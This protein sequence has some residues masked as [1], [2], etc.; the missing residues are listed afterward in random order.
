[1][2]LA[3]QLHAGQKKQG[4]SAHSVFQAIPAVWSTEG[5][6]AREIVGPGVSGPAGRVGPGCAFLRGTRSRLLVCV[7]KRTSWVWSQA[8]SVSPGL[9]SHQEAAV[10]RHPAADHLRGPI[11]RHS[12]SRS[13]AR[14]RLTSSP[15]TRPATTRAATTPPGRWWLAR[16]TVMSALPGMAMGPRRFGHTRRVRSRVT[17]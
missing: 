16:R 15:T 5:T 4:H 1:M 9:D 2:R 3:G 11:I 6:N 14:A 13:V 17:A 10:R 7:G 12:G 8:R